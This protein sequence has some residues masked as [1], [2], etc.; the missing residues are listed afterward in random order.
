MSD[1]DKDRQGESRFQRLRRTASE[2]LGSEAVR[3]A[4]ETTK[5]VA[6]LGFDVTAEAAS[7]GVHAATS[8]VQGARKTITQ[9][10]AWEQMQQSITDL[11]DVARVQHA[12]ILD[13]LSRVERLETAAKQDKVAS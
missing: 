11:T 4:I 9:E 7:R 5:D 1:D 13:L 3:D 10:E 8:L 6:G 2:L 12:M